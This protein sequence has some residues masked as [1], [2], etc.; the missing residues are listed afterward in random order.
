M[1]SAS[2]FSRWSPWGTWAAVVAIVLVGTVLWNLLASIC[3]LILGL[4]LVCR[5]DLQE[6]G[7][8]R[9]LWPGVW[10][11]HP[12]LGLGMAM[13]LLFLLAAF[14]PAWLAPHDPEAS[15]TFLLEVGDRTYAAPY[16]PNPK[17]P[18]G[19][20]YEARDL[21]SRVIF[22]ARPTLTLVFYAVLMR[23]A[24]G[25]ALGMLAS[26]PHSRAAQVV[27]TASAVSSAFPSLLFAFMFIVA[28]GPGAGI[29]V[30]LLGLGLTGWAHW[31]R[32]IGTEVQRIRT[33]PYMLA[34][35]ALGTPPGM[36]LRR[37]VLPGLLPL[38]LPGAAHEL[39]AVM[40]LLAELGFI[41]IFFGESVVISVTDLLRQTAMPNAVEWGGML[42]GTRAEVFHWYWLPLVPA[43]AFFISIMGFNMLAGGMQQV[44]DIT[45]AAATGSG[46]MSRTRWQ[47]RRAKAHDARHHTRPGQLGQPPSV[48]IPETRPG[49]M[50]HPVGMALLI[51]LVLG[52]G[53]AVGYHAHQQSHIQ[54]V[55]RQEE[56]LGALLASAQ[57]ALGVN[58]YESAQSQ[59]RAYLAAR[60]DDDRARSGLAQAEAGLAFATLVVEARAL[61][62]QKQW[63]EALP[64]LRIINAQRP[65]YGGVADL[66]AEG[67]SHLETSVMFQ[68]AQDAYARRDWA[69]AIALYEQVQAADREF[70]WQTL[71]TALAESYA[72]R[73]LQL[74]DT[75]AQDPTVWKEVHELLG[76]VLPYRPSDVALQEQH[77][78]MQSLLQ[79]QQALDAQ[80]E[81]TA[82]GHVS[83]LR[84][85]FPVLS[86]GQA[87]RWW[88]VGIRILRDQ[89]Q[90]QGLDLAVAFYTQLDHVL[91]TGSGE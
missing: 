75:G 37:H 74:M 11:Q 30:F 29:P 85:T 5:R 13:V 14:F 47:W 24:L 4:A 34:A 50:R 60:P 49:Y 83:I 27:H 61:A 80:D 54:T 62:A 59:F 39:S 57:Q 65:N 2:P 19:S 12:M 86:D 45:G 36:Q 16:P 3:L 28:V 25:I 89:A 77:S 90:R 76:K 84:Q 6:W 35:E 8:H 1:Q 21:L 42:A 46:M 87:E 20:D 38:I 72:H 15:G 31:T 41:G 81:L 82:V 88:R 63:T 56:E 18:L 7:M 64:L 23:M 22:G 91:A 71:R 26:V 78:V 53:G 55:Q 10:L 52:L 66:I 33:Q 79:A 48:S 73:A 58:R 43:G 68:A 40:L 67:E 17:Y 70:E 44:L 69:V 51:L 9:L 32:M